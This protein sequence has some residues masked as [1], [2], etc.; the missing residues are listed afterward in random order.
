MTLEEHAIAW[1]QEKGAE[2]PPLDSAEWKRMYEEW[3][4]WAFSNL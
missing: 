2:I 4:V 1:W 3:A